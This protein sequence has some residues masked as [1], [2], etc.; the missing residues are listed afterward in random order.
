MYSTEQFNK[1]IEDSDMKMRA[2]YEKA[3]MSKQVFYD[4]RN[5][6]WNNRLTRD[7]ILVIADVIGAKVSDY[8]PELEKTAAQIMDKPLEEY[9]SHKV[10]NQVKEYM[11][12]L[13][14]EAKKFRDEYVNVLKENN[15]L[16]AEMIDMLREKPSM[17][18]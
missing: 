5:P 17:S 15:R 12:D 1:M 3:G 16:Q 14:L 2:I 9:Q 7:K 11:E 13:I 6:E 10:I 8:F 4:I 18:E